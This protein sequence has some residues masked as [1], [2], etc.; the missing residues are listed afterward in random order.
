[1]KS[2]FELGPDL[3]R[4]SDTEHSREADDLARHEV[5][6]ELDENRLAEV[7]L[8][9]APGEAD[10]A[11]VPRVAKRGLELDHTGKDFRA[12]GNRSTSEI[13]GQVGGV[14]VLQRAQPD[15]DNAAALAAVAG[16]VRLGLAVSGL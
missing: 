10:A 6:V 12:S 11:D 5:A 14:E 8:L 2:R 4:P 15:E 7:G 1:P 16:G 9:E 3:S 13:V